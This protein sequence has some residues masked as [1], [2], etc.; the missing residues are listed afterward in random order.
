M[1]IEVG[2][3]YR[4]V[5]AGMPHWL[6]VRKVLLNESGAGKIAFSAL[7]QNPEGWPSLFRRIYFRFALFYTEGAPRCS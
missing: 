5:F 2:K 4:G 7:K 6:L 1:T 3:S